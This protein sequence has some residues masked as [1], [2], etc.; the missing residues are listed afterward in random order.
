MLFSC[1][2][3]DING[4]V[5]AVISLRNSTWQISKDSIQEHGSFLARMVNTQRASSL[6]YKKL[7]NTKS[8]TADISQ[9]KRLIDCEL[10]N[11][12]NINRTSAYC[13]PR[14]CTKRTKL[15]EFHFKFLHRR[16]PTNNFLCEIGL[17]DNNNC[18]F[19]KETPETSIH[20]FWSCDTI[21]SFW[22]D[23]TE[24]LRKAQ[25]DIRRLYNGDHYRL[26]AEAGHFK[27]CTPNKLL[28]SV[29]RDT[30][31]AS[32]IA[33][34]RNSITRDS[35]A[36]SSTEDRILSFAEFYAL[37]EEQ[38]QEGF[39]PLKKKKKKTL[40]KSAVPA[41]SVGCRS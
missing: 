27:I 23:V 25:F 20:L 37:R 11:K 39:L 1:S 41:K 31:T 17:K 29:T 18:T 16:I 28:S 2:K 26:G 6:V 21:S 24:W 7:V 34:M 14:R 22:N 5:A 10:V 38:R 12:K 36:T 9:K 40:G 3:G 8:K 13:L 35:Q 4:I 33:E 30:D 19:C 32:A 15:I